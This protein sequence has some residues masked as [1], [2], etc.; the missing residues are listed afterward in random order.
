[1]IDRNH[2]VEKNKGTKVNPSHNVKSCIEDKI[3]PNKESDYM[4]NY[5]PFISEG[6]VS[7]VGDQN[8][9]QKVKILRDTGAT[10]SLMLDS[11]LPLTE[12]SFTGANV[13]ISGLEMGVLEVPL[14]E[15]N[16]K[17]SLINGNIVIGL[18]PS[19]PVEGISLILVNDLAGEKVMV[20]PRAVEKLRDDEKTERL[21]KKFQGIFPASV[22]TCSMKTKKEAIKEQGKEEIGLSGTFLENIDGKF[23]ERNKE[24]AQKALIRNESRNVKGNIPVKQ[25]SE[26]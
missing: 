18:R 23:E 22:V 4:E 16:I 21:A 26:R 24:K 25:K 7:L 11:V 13:L 15:V 14:H 20:D 19:I 5:K 8:S 3:C 17:S 10:Q 9:S 12:N 2:F 1:M 6:V